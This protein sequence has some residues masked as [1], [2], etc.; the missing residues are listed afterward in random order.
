MIIKRLWCNNIDVIF[1]LKNV[2]PP[3]QEIVFDEIF[4]SHIKKFSPPNKSEIVM[5]KDWNV[6]WLWCG[7]TH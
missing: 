7:G 2:A 4:T 5:S 3:T 1:K 6:P